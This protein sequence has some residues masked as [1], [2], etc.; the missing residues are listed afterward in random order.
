MDEFNKSLQNDSMKKIH[1]F[2][3]LD[4]EKILF[5]QASSSLYASFFFLSLF[6]IIGNIYTVNI[7]RPF[8]KT[9]KQLRDISNGNKM[10][11]KIMNSINKRNV[12]RS[13]TK[14]Y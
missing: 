13:N 10:K 2:L 5:I 8:W 4:T 1:S 3:F 9:T 14:L 12:M 7:M 11:I 6:S